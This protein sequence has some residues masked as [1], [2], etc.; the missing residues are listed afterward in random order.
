MPPREIRHPLQTALVPGKASAFLNCLKT[1][2]RF[3]WPEP[4]LLEG[5]MAP[6]I[7]PSSGQRAEMVSKECADMSK[8]VHVR[9][10]YTCVHAQTCPCVCACALCI[11]VCAPTC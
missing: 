5:D 1:G 10:V 6:D 7:D 4:V 3:H 9:C 11:H 8:C 2:E